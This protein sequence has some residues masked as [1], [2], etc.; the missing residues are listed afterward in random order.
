[1]DGLFSRIRHFHLGLT[2][3]ALA[4]LGIAWPCSTSAAQGSEIPL[5]ITT[6]RLERLIQ[7]S[8]LLEDSNLTIL[9]V[10]PQSNYRRRHIPKAVSLP[11]KKLTD[12]T[13]RIQGKRLPDMQ[14]ARTFGRT[15]IGKDSYVVVYDNVGGHLAAR[16]LW[17]MHYLGHYR[18]SVLDGGIPKWKAEGRPITTKSI[19]RPARRRLFPIDLAPQHLATTDYVLEHLDDPNTVIVDVR[20]PKMYAAAHMPGAVNLPWKRSLTPDDVWR[21]LD[22]L[23]ATFEEAGVT[24]DKNVIVYCQYGNMN[25]HTYMTLKLLGYTRVRSYDLAWAGWSRDPSLP[26]VDA[27]GNPAEVE[28]ESSQETELGFVEPGGNQEKTD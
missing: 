6:D 1:M 22:E 23:R 11:F 16:V 3:I 26:K 25:H 20:P 19:D 7:D 28:A 2:A 10:Q 13:S 18:V 14:L 21:P 8:D 12:L 5:L 27:S 4:F 24:K 15:G 17:L 9:D